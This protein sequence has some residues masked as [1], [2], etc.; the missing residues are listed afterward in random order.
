MI[1]FFPEASKET[2]KLVYSCNYCNHKA[3]GLYHYRQHL[4]SH[5]GFK[6]LV[7]GTQIESRLKCGYCS[8]L[9]VDDDDFKSHMEYHFAT[10]PFSC[11]YCNFS[12]Y[13]ASG[14]TNHIKRSHP[15]KTADVVKESDSSCH[16]G[17][18]FDAKAMI[19]DFEPNVKLTDI[20]AM[21]PED[22]E[23][24]LNKCEVCV[25]DLNYIPDEKFDA[26]SKTLG[27]E[28]EERNVD[29]ELE[30]NAKKV[31]RENICEDKQ[32]LDESEDL[33][34]M[35]ANGEL[36]IEENQK[37]DDVSDDDLD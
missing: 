1:L 37:Y 35:I 13:R 23:K 16:I 5:N 20:F 6:H 29:D 31:K 10:R 28:N 27:L 33:E 3:N 18:E 21:D 15:G 32:Q 14:I 22:F 34:T 19:V 8:Y 24:L 26:V 2:G 7:P 36:K 9:A 12:Q 11:P 30:P 17:H 4:A 25:I